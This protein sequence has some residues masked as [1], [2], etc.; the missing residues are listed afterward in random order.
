MNNNSD[1]ETILMQ[2]LVDSVGEDV[3]NDILSDF[4]CEYSNGQRNNGVE[5]FLHK[6]AI[7]FSNKKIS[8]TYLVFD[9]QNRITGYFTLT[10]KP[11]SVKVS[12]LKSKTKKKKMERYAEYDEKLGSYS[13]SAFLIA[14]FSKNYNIPKDERI[15]GDAL[16]NITLSI[17]SDIQQQIGGG[18]VFLECEDE[19]KLIE[20]YSKEPNT[21]IPFGERYS[22]ESGGIKYIQMMRFI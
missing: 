2:D 20:F 8:I 22:S 15:S 6:N 19:K 13:A 16:M 10:H 18:I 1:F 4:S 12:K 3:V 5:N 7:D 14:Q 17:L 9:S 21:F 11:I